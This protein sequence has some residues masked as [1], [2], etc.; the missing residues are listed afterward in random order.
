MEARIQIAFEICRCIY[1]SSLW[2]KKSNTH[3]CKCANAYVEPHTVPSHALAPAEGE[4][5]EISPILFYKAINW[6]ASGTT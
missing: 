6:S 5:C 1:T 2:G 4:P 3:G